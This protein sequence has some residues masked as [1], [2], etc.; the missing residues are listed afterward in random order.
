MRG[1]APVAV[2]LEQYCGADVLAEYGLAG[3]REKVI[4]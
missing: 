3:I 2:W 1:G 4:L